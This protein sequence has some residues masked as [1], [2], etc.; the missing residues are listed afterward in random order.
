MSARLSGVR[1]MNRRNMP[2]DSGAAFE[3]VSGVSLRVS[4]D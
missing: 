1:W 4:V 2:V 3:R